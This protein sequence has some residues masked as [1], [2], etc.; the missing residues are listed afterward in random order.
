[1][2]GYSIKLATFTLGFS[3]NHFLFTIFLSVFFLKNVSQS[4]NERLV[5]GADGSKSE[6]TGK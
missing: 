2:C 4:C 3:W 5:D 6:P 1:M